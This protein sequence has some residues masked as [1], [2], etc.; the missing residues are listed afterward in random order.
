MGFLKSSLSTFVPTISGQST[1]GAGTY[2]LQAG[3]FQRIGFL[4]FI[5]GSVSW[6]ARTGT[7]NMLITDLPFPVNNSS[8][9][10]PECSVRTDNI[11]W[12]ASTSYIFGE[13][14]PGTTICELIAIKNGASPVQVSMSGS[15]AVHFTGYYLG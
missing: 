13:F 12:P 3:Y 14:Q 9:Y 8:N 1:A 15:G 11:S 2:T 10:D 6:S 7:G 5:T 4:V